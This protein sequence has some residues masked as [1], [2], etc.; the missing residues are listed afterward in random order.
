[1]WFTLTWQPLLKQATS[2]EWEMRSHKVQGE[3]I[4]M[5]DVSGGGYYNGSCTERD[6]YF[7]S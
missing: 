2:A 1:M 7:L 6:L 4:I 5:A 3:G